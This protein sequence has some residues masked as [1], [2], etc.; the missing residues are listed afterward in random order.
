MT[1]AQR[2]KPFVNYLE[3]W[4]GELPALTL[5][6]AAPDPGRAALLCVDI[7]NGFCTI[8]PLSSPR[9]QAI[10][11]PITRLFKAAHKHGVR[12]FVLTQDTHAPDAVEFSHYPP[13]CV[14]G[15][16]ESQTAPELARLA[17]SDLFVRF[18]KNSISSAHNTALDRW[19]EAH[20]ELDTFIVVG[21]CTDLCTHQL[22]MHLR[23]RA[24]ARQLSGVRVIVPANCVQTYDTPLATARKLGIAPHD[25]DLL[26][27]V[28]LRNMAGN[29]VEVV[30]AL[31]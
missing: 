22:A 13:H 29:G 24:N 7:I 1:L 10:V 6:K 11:A 31:R 26:H 9:V 8:G 16:A 17:F 4:L 15:T 12:R 14:R 30:A 3:T 21:D 5:K 2:S 23:L 25:G 20:P 19:L 18:E 28:F 27:A